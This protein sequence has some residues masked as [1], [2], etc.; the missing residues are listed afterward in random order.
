MN[1]R[2]Q[3]LDLARERL[4]DASLSEVFGRRGA[5]A[6]PPKAERRGWLAAAIVLLGVAVVVASAS[7]Q[8]R[9]D[10]NEADGPANPEQQDPQGAAPLPPPVPCVS[11]EQLRSMDVA[12]ESLLLVLEDPAA[13]AQVGRL[14]NLRMLVV[15][16]RDDG[17]LSG[18]HELDQ[19]GDALAAI[20]KL[21]KLE[22]L[23]LP[24]AARLCAEHVRSLAGATSLRFLQ[25]PE[26]TPTTVEFAAAL[27]AMPA[28]RELRLSHATVQRG[29][30]E[31]L[32]SRG[33]TRLELNACPVPQ[34]STYAE[35]GKLGTVR[36]LAV[37]SVTG[38]AEELPELGEPAF[39]AFEQMAGLVDLDL[40][41]T[42][43]PDRFMKRLPRRL[44]RLRLG[45]HKMTPATL[46]DLKRLDD[47]EELLF[48]H[49]T[50]CDA[51]VDLLGALRLRKVSL[52]GWLDRSVLEAIAVHPSIEHVTLRLRGKVELEPLASARRL[53]T[54]ELRYDPTMPALGPP[55]EELLQTL[56]DNGVAV[57]VQQS[58]RKD[59]VEIVFDRRK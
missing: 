50:H 26:H 46:A 57:G 7:W 43:F 42:N 2:E 15:L 22:S 6:P 28:L 38:M 27:T 48:H 51:V 16:N 45:Y 32:A 37:R 13:L 40:D 35:L 18:W 49:A 53:R 36:H 5:V 41:E 21:R 33:L 30:L 54:L 44:Q 12:T 58:L 39:A 10:R 24:P 19:H 23:Q 56:R 20:G 55:S 59:G 34:A 17:D 14:Q 9:A 11:L 52:H 25:L 47:L 4:L 31:T 1:D 8:S 29:F 3:D